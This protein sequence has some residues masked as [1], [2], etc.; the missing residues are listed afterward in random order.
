MPGGI[1]PGHSHHRCLN[2]SQMRQTMPGGL[3]GASVL[4]LDASLESYLEISKICQ[5]SGTIFTQHT[6]RT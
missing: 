4:S 3:G 5:T 1:T 6:L 2:Q